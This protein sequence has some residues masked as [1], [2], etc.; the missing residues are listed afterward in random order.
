MM[1]EKMLRHL[2]EIKHVEEVPVEVNKL[3]FTYMMNFA[4][5][6]VFFF[7]MLFKGEPTMFSRIWKIYWWL[8]SI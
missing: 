8:L 6:V 7:V 5:A 2:L 1:I 4:F 3:S